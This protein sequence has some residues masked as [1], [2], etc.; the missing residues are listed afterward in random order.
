[1]NDEK[2]ITAAFSGHR[3]YDGRD[4][5]KL[6][7]IIEQLYDVGFRRFLV[8]MAWGFDLA[9]ARLV[10]RL[11]SCKPDVELVAVEPYCGFRL[12]FKGDDAVMY[13]D[14]LAAADDRVAVGEVSGVKSLMERNRYLVDNASHLVAWWNREKGSG[15]AYTVGYAKRQYVTV[16]NIYPRE[17][18]LFSMIDFGDEM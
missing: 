4:D 18:D 6:Y 11:K 1:M 5:E 7:A 10:V 9:A 16:E 12:L 2:N 14:I 13:D 8:G 17:V 3:S 15:T